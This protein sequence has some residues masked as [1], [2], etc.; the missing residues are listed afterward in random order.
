MWR[1]ATS[2]VAM[3]ICCLFVGKLKRL[4]GWLGGV[5]SQAIK[6]ALLRGPWILTDDDL[7]AKCSVLSIWHIFAACC[8]LFLFLC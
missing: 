1:L 2:Q 8:A 5:V 6:L 7:E 3:F 4:D